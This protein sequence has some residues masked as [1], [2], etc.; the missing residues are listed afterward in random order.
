MSGKLIFFDID[1]TILNS[2]Y[3]IPESTVIAMKELKA[4]GHICVACT[5]RTRVNLRHE[6]IEALRFDGIIAACG[7]YIEIGGK[8]IKNDELEADGVLRAFS[9]IKG[10]K[11]PTIFEGAESQYI[12]EWGFEHNAYVKYLLDGEKC[13]TKLINEF[14]PETKIN[15]FSMDV[16]NKKAYLEVKEAIEDSFTFIEHFP[17]SQ[18][19]IENWRIGVAE[20]IN[21]NISKA[22]GMKEVCRFFG[23]SINDS[24]AVG[25][26]MNDVE[27][28][29]SAGTGIVMGNSN[30]EVRRFADYVTDD[31]NENGIFNAMKHFSLI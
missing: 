27:M 21:K 28:L 10:N 30:E 23:E 24:F 20:V 22:T 26:S 9:I 2:E 25:D 6:N 14:S 13:K 15:K 19:K 12:T 17:Y 3:I 7:A 31:I 16:T 18:G 4:N 8:I 29:I 5:G 1:G 11:I